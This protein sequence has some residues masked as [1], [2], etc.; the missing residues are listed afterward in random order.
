M[1]AAGITVALFAVN[2]VLGFFGLTAWLYDPYGQL[3]GKKA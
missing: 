1:Y 3:F 2:F